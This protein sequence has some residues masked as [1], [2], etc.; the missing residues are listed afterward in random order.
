MAADSRLAAPRSSLQYLDAVAL[1]DRIR[2]QLVRHLRHAGLS[3]SWIGVGQ[4]HLKELALA[5]IRD[6]GI[7]ERDERVG[8]DAALRI[9]DGGFQRDVD[10]SFHAVNTLLNT[11]STLRSC[12]FKS[13][14]FSISAAGNT[15]VTSGS[16]SRSPLKSFCSW[17]ERIA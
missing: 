7:T 12:S 11:A 6:V 1:D 14:A 10:A 16:A 3:G 5:N 15:L 9:E 4:L 2:E 17:N 8:N 13:N